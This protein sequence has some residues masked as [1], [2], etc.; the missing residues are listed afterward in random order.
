MT[1]T[2][3]K[4]G[5]VGRPSLPRPLSPLAG[6]RGAQILGFVPSGSTKAG[7]QGNRTLRRPRR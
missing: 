2:P 3:E 1:P 4:T 7:E 5:F 6:E